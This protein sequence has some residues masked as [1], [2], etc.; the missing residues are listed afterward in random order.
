MVSFDP[1]NTIGK[2]G[3]S[4]TRPTAMLIDADVYM[5]LDEVKASLVSR[6]LGSFFCVA[7]I[8]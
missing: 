6:T 7:N 5:F 2:Y 8:L 4:A 1:E 3:Q